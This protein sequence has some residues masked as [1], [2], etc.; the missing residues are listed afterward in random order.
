M[1]HK[2]EWCGGP[3]CG[4]PFDRC[5]LCGED[6]GLCRNM[7]SVPIVET[8]RWPLKGGPIATFEH[9]CATCERVPDRIVSFSFYQHDLD[10]H[11]PFLPYPTWGRPDRPSITRRKSS[12]N[13][14]D[15]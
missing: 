5:G 8:V 3:D 13:R 12:P 1:P 2:C 6:M 14:K 4:P 10:E 7:D 11:K 9:V 15:D